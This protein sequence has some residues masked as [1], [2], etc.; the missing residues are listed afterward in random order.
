MKE[1]LKENPRP[2]DA[3]VLFALFGFCPSPELVLYADGRC[4]VRHGP[5]EIG[6]SGAKPPAGRSVALKPCIPDCTSQIGG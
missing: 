1:K 2:L 3:R 5:L 4:L 6:R